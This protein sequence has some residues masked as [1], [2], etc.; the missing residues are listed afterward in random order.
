MQVSEAH[1][2][3]LNSVQKG[4]GISIISLGDSCTPNLGF[5]VKG[6]TGRVACVR[7]L[8]DLLLAT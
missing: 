3:L 6:R 5:S 2:A 8:E 7:S 1:T 4:V